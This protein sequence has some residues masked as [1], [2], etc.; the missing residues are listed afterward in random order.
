MSNSFFHLSWWLDKWF[1]LK[2]FFTAIIFDLSY[3]LQMIYF[4][5]YWLHIKYLNVTHFFLERKRAPTE[6]RSQYR[7]FSGAH[8]A[9]SAGVESRR[10]KKCPR[11]IDQV[12]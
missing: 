7:L 12:P 3:S 1:Y 5:W 4:N 6:S 10:R 8:D 2:K 11:Q 9:G